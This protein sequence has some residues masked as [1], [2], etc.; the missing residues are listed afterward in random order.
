MIA[1]VIVIIINTIKR[2]LINA[3]HI[4]ING[5]NLCLV[6]ELASDISAADN[7]NIKIIIPYS[8]S[9]SI[10]KADKIVGVAIEII[11]IQKQTYCI[12]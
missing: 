8:P 6:S 10:S 9:S 12:I 5:A 11:F 4:S 1:F 3:L 7:N 2:G